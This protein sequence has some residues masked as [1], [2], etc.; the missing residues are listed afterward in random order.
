ME[1][2][3][4]DLDTLE[5]QRIQWEMQHVK[6]FLDA[7]GVGADARANLR[8]QSMQERANNRW[9]AFT[10]IN[11]QPRHEVVQWEEILESDR[12]FKI[13]Q[14]RQLGRGNAEVYAVK[15]LDNGADV[16]VKVVDI[17]GFSNLFKI[18]NM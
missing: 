16:A 6:D 9:R 18:R 10:S 12:R 8:T 7:S 3:L 1:T 14:T 17:R 4:H 5:Q 11:S 2:E 15:A 13:D